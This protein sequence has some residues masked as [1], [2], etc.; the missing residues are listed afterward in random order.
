MKKPAI[1]ILMI[2]ALLLAG[3]ASQKPVWQQE[4]ENINRQW[5]K[6]DAGKPAPAPPPSFESPRDQYGPRAMVCR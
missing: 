5:R 1:F 3:C 6:P 2:S 4:L